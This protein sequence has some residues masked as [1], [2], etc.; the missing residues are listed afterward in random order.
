MMRG[1]TR[2]NVDLKVKT[3][4]GRFFRSVA[5][6]MRMRHYTVGYILDSK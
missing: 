5:K 1:L 4:V 6:M 2:K 3:V